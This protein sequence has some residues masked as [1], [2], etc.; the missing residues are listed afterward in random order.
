MTILREAPHNL[1]AFLREAPHDLKHMDIL[2]V[3]FGKLEQSSVFAALC[4]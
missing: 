1:K 4:Q 2:E 3:I